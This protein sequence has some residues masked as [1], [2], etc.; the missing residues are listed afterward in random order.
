MLCSHGPRI[1][2]MLEISTERADELRC[3]SHILTVWIGNPGG[4]H[5]A[6]ETSLATRAFV[7]PDRKSYDRSS[8]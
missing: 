6:G 5:C 3:W 1:S 2:A 8:Q 7:G 4:S